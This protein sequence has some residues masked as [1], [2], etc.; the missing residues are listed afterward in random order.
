MSKAVNPSSE[1]TSPMHRKTR[2][3]RRCAQLVC[4]LFVVLV[5]GCAPRGSI[6]IKPPGAEQGSVQDVFVAST[7]KLVEGSAV[8]SGTRSPSMHYF[9]FSVAVPPDHIPGTVRFPRRRSP[10]LQTD[11]VTISATQFRDRSAFVSSLNSVARQKQPQDREVVLF[12]HGFNTN[13]AEGLYRQ[14]QLSHDFGSRGISVNFSWASA[15]DL[16]AYAYDRESALLARD[17]LES[18][19]LS[20]SASNAARIVII[21]HS[22]GAQVVMETLRQMEIRGAPVFFDKLSSVVLVAPDI[23]VDLF[24]NQ[25]T[26]LAELDIPL[27]IFVSSRDRALRLSSLLRGR[28]PRLGMLT[29]AAALGDLPVAIIDTSDVGANGDPLQHFKAA[30][31]P[32][33]IALFAGMGTAG[34]E[35]FQ[36]GQNSPGLL[37]GG[38]DA[39]QD[40]AN[41]VLGG[42]AGPR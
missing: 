26:P 23:D 33:M 19:L 28:A 38:V 6:S 39:I 13:F 37:Q 7:R 3:H 10:N 5:A 1:T 20:V 41:V 12:V 35:M 21:A 9:N 29:D 34:L 8:L 11:F 25:A 42:P 4:I 30:S 27:Y 22:M 18:V 2:P 31:S 15:G 24:V 14:A 16:R 32:T 40:A 36:E 17:G